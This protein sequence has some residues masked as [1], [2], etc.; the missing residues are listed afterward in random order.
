[1]EAWPWILSHQ[2]LSNFT[3]LPQK[4]DLLSAYQTRGSTHPVADLDGKFRSSWANSKEESRKFNRF[5]TSILGHEVWD[6]SISITFGV[7]S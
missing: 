4:Q 7:H 6:K 3:T 1:M 2:Q 5:E